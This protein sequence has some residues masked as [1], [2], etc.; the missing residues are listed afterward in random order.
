MN[1]IEA[2]QV[3]V[4]MGGHRILTDVSFNVAAGDVVAIV[5]PNGSGKSTLM[6]AMLGLIPFQGEIRIFG[7]A[8]GVLSTEGKVSRTQR[9][10]TA[11]AGRR[12]GYVPQH[13]DFDRTMPVTVDELLSVHLAPGGC[14]EAIGAALAAT[15]AAH[16][17]HRMIGVLSGGEFQ[18]V[19]LS[20][21]LLNTPDILFLDEPA[22]GVDME[23][24]AEFYDLIQGLRGQKNMTIVMVSHDM[25]VVFRHATQV[26]CI[27]HALICTG[28]PHDALT[29]DTMR[30]L[31]GTEQSIY[32]HKEKRHD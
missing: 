27:N 10:A 18:R 8:P 32:S 20:L 2:R 16:L 9:A 12:V 15:G 5:G 19:L 4:T 7:V 13:L 25:D 6:K 21:A 22:S 3:S 1:A 31:Y 28:A 17:R 29:A 11:A 26:L 30:R 14:R 24:V 23:G